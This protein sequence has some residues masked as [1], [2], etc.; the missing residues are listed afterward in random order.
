MTVSDEALQ[1][2]VKAGRELR[3]RKG[4]LI[5]AGSPGGAFVG[6]TGT[7]VRTVAAGTKV[8]V[9]VTGPNAFGD[10]RRDPWWPTGA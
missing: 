9:N 6:D 3:S 5:V 7:A 8:E 4:E 2:L 1:V 10:G